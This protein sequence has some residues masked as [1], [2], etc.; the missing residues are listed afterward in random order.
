MLYWEGDF[1]HKVLAMGILLD[2]HN[3]QQLQ[4]YLLRELMSTGRLNYPVPMKIDGEI[5]T[6]TIEKN[7]PVSFVV[8]TTR[9]KLN[10]ENETRMLSLELSDTPEQ[11]ARAMRMIARV[12]GLNESGNDVDF[13]PWRDFQRWLAA[14]ETRVYI[15]FAPE[16]AK[17]IPP[18]AVRVRRDFA[19]VLAAIKAHALLHREHRARDRGEIVATIRTTTAPSAA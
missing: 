3:S 1:Q 6:V 18:K 9:T 11:T 19:Q 17:L 10:P 7:G 14:G 8:T 2:D 4:D 5:K 12:R 13:T 15:P 16:L